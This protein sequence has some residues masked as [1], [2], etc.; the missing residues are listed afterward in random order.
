MKGKSV[1]VDTG[2]GGG[3]SHLCFPMSAAEVKTASVGD[4]SL[5]ELLGSDGPEIAG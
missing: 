4:R 5:E 2:W 3:V 1:P